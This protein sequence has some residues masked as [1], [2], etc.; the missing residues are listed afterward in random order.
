M[1][2]NT[3]MLAGAIA[4]PLQHTDNWQ[5]PDKSADFSLDYQLESP[6]QVIAVWLSIDGDDTLCRYTTTINSLVLEG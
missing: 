5:L 6:Q 1:K 2:L 3:L 4:L